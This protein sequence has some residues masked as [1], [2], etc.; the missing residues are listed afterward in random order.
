MGYE[1]CRLVRTTAIR[2]AAWVEMPWFPD[3]V[4]ALELAR[5]QTRQAGKADPVGQYFATL[6]SGDL[7]SLETVWPGDVVVYDPRAGEVRGHRELRRFVRQNQEWF[8]ERLASIETVAT[9]CS[10]G[11]AVVELLAHLDHASGVLDW[12][13]AVVA[14]SLDQRSA[15]FRTYCSQ[16]PV[17][18]RRHLRGPILEPGP[19]RLDDV[20]GQYLR[21]FDAGDVE[22]AVRLF[23]ANGYVREPIGPESLHRGIGELG[24]LFRAWFSSGGIGLEPCL[25]TDDGRRSALEYTCF[26]WGDQD[27]PPQAGLTVYERDQNGLLAAVR[28]YDDIERPVTPSSPAGRGDQHLG[29]SE[30]THT[31]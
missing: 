23:P 14:E 2:K 4:G 11:R 8:A 29:I 22:A 1:E 27:L 15:V 18:G 30:Q 31:A 25:M 21:S 13:V 9:T 24:A 7:E 28:L 10:D 20:V 26:R 12:P 5:K 17:D 19:V 3:F 16:V 6:T